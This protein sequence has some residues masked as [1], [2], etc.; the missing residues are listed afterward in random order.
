MTPLAVETIESCL[1]LRN[2]LSGVGRH[3]DPWR[4]FGRGGL[5]EAEARCAAANRDLLAFVRPPKKISVDNLTVSPETR[6]RGPRVETLRFDSPLPSGRPTNDRVQAR[7]YRPPRGE[8]L[9][10]VVVFHHPIY[11]RHWALWEWFLSDVIARIP[12]VMMAAPYHFERLPPGE[13]PGEGICNPN[14]WRMFE[15][16]RQWCWDERVLRQVVR[17]HCGLEPVAAIGYSVGAFLTLLAA[18]AGSLTAP[19]VSIAST[20][21]YA[22]GVTRGTIGRGIMEGMLR[23]G[24]DAGRLHKMTESV[25]LERYA[26]RLR[27]HP[28]LYVYGKYDRVDPPPSLERLERAL[29]PT[30]VVRLDVGHATIMLRRERVMRETRSFLTDV[31]AL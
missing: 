17:E 13:F 30:R 8:A 20:N 14:P 11:Q 16:F 10:R 2:R 7:L 25:Q 12:V 31:G 6:L 29:R 26:P 5:A 19:V 3:P 18:A 22:H 9:D 27:N 1:R 15:A 28:V 4:H 24:I 23:V 21:R